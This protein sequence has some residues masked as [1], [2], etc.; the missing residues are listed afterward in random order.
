MAHRDIIVIGGSTGALD[1]LREIVGALP[2][3]LGAAIFVVTHTAPDAPCVLADILDRAGP[4]PA[5]MARNGETIRPGRIYVAPPDH[6]LILE[7]GKVRLTRGPRE[8]R[9]RPAID[10]LFRSAAQIYGPRVIGVILTGRLDDGTSGLWTVRQLGGVAVVQDPAEAVAPSMPASALQHV[11][12]DHVLPVAEISPAL[13][14]LT[15]S[16][17]AGFTEEPHVPDEL[18]IELNIA[19]GNDA[20]EAGIT[21]L[22]E[23]STFACP[24]CHG[25]LLQMK[26]VVPPRFR[27]HTGH[28]YTLGAL[29]DEMDDAIEDS[30]WNALR[31]IQ[32]QTM[33]LRRAQ[34]HLR[35]NHNVRAADELLTRLE[36][37]M[38]QAVTVR[39]VV[40]HRSSIEGA[41]TADLGV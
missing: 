2:P 36:A 30:L 23:A 11:H 7:P 8:N 1:A 26:N 38:R 41:G 5:A 18:N 40:V 27:C 3:S 9:F 25:V 12:V 28:G 33:L 21:T 14:R 4:L 15:S 34:E 17:I 35:D 6:H 32:E 16:S 37:R 24:E 31:A 19:S 20:L 29:L 13:V 10:P 39:G 22:G